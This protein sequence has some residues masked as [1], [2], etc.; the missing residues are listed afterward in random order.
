MQ[1]WYFEYASQ[2]LFM[3]EFKNIN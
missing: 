2:Y 1:L 3:E